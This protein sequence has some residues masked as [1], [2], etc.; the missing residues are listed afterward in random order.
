M[1]SKVSLFDFHNT[2]NDAPCKREWDEATGFSEAGWWCLND[3]TGCL[4]NDGNN[5][6][7]HR[8]NSTSPLEEQSND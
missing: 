6:C 3:H 1:T 2:G 7:S 8:G 4:F 5:T